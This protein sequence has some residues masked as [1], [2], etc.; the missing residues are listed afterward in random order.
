M[1]QDLLYIVNLPIV[2][3]YLVYSRQSCCCGQ[4][5]MVKGFVMMWSSLLYCFNEQLYCCAWS[6]LDVVHFIVINNFVNGAVGL[7]SQSTE[8]ICTSIYRRY[9]SLLHSTVGPTKQ[10]YDCKVDSI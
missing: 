5:C 4:L 7:F 3:N 10:K 1:L 2:F 6:C 8:L 9:Y